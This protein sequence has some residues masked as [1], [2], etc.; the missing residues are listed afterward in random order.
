MRRGLLLAGLAGLIL[1]GGVWWWSP[2]GASGPQKSAKARPAKVVMVA[3]VRLEPVERRVASVGTVRSVES[4]TITAESQGVIR[5]LL[6]DDGARVKAGAVL[7]RLDAEVERA[8]LASA[9][10][11]MEQAKSAFDRARTLREK[12]VG[13][14]S[15]LEVAQVSLRTAEARVDLARARLS[16][17]T[18][19]APFD[20]ILS[21][22]KVS[23]GAHVQAGDPLATLEALGDV[24]VDFRLAEDFIGMVAKGQPVSVHV[25]AY[26]GRTFVGTL[27]DVDT[28]IDIASRQAVVRAMLPNPDFTLRPGMLAEVSLLLGSSDGILLPELAV[29]SVGPS[30]F[31]FIVTPDKPVERR[32]VVLGPRRPGKVQIVQG[33]TPGEMVVVEGAAKLSDG[34]MVKAQPPTASPVAALP[35]VG[36]E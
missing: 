35:P 4:V 12:G 14:V 16:K 18:V 11:E 2:L 9:Q 36:R 34:D 8:E 30:P 25:R 32:A 19:T 26:A 33:L 23:L 22:R 28:V 1:A 17:R 24:H 13:T 5:E 27:K 3:P 7:A 15:V 21:F 31:V 20:G 10:A 6:F 29:Q